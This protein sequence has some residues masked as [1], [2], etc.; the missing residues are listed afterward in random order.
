M[1]QVKERRSVCCGRRA[2]VLNTSDTYP[3]R[4]EQVF[5]DPLGRIWRDCVFGLCGVTDVRRRTFGVVVT[6]SPEERA[7]WLDEVEQLT[8]DVFPRADGS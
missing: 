5:G 3:E 8:R 2:L 1:T 6:S 7:R 4:E